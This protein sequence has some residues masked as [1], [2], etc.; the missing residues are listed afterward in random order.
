MNFSQKS[1]SKKCKSIA[2]YII[3]FDFIPFHKLK[4][5]TSILYFI[6]PAAFNI[7]SHNKIPL[8]QDIHINGFEYIIHF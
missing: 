7:K 3:K 1:I 6:F 2:C 8:S 4:H 5:E